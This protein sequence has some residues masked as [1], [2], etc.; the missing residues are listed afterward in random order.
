MAQRSASPKTRDAA[1]C[2]DLVMQTGIRPGSD[3]D[4]GA[5]KKA[6][7]ATTLKGQHVVT[8]AGG[9]RLQFTGKKGVSLDIPIEDPK[10]AAT[11]QERAKKAGPDGALFPNVTDKSLLDHTHTMGDG[12]FRTKDFR[13]HLGTETAAKL[14]AAMPAPTDAKAHKAAVMAVAKQVAAKLGNTPVIAIASYIAP[15]VWSAWGAKNV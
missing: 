7:G 1:D 6:Y 14:V 3:N 11:L 4:T 12:S 8:D 10:L 15:E 2:L 9:T 5:D 13:T